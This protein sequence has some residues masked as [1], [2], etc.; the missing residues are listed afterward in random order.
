[1]DCIWAEEVV[2]FSRQEWGIVFYFIE[3]VFGIFLIERREL[4]IDFIINKLL[5]F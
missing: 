1:M 5:A 2:V 4:L 3:I